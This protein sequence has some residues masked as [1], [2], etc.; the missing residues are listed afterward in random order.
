MHCLRTI[1]KY[2]ALLLLLTGLTTA[3][4]EIVNPAEELP[5]YISFQD[6]TVLLDENTGFTYPAGLKDLWLYHGGV[7]E[8]VYPIN[9]DEDPNSVLTVPYIDL[10][11]TNFFAQGGILESGLSTFRLPYVFWEDLDFTVSQNPGDTFLVTPVFR[12]ID[13]S[14][15]ELEVDEDFEG[16]SFSLIP[17]NRA[18][19]TDD[20][21]YLNRTTD[22]FMGNFSGIV[23]FGTDDR[24]FEVISATPFPLALNEDVYAEI[25]YKSTVEFRVGLVYQGLTGLF[26][27]QVLTVTPQEDWNTV[28]VHLIQQVRD[29]I[30]ANNEFT[31]FWL[32]IFADGEGNDGYICFD[33]VRLIHQK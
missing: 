21:T 3:G 28:Y 26:T 13:D 16:S 23:D 25:T 11:N 33:N 32:W 17:F 24:W 10:L 19:T 27:E 14:R 20:S 31:N 1:N 12:Y 18:L 2:F 9:N 4:C 8:G 30:N 15:Y 29:I 7:L 22:A 6:A 5:A